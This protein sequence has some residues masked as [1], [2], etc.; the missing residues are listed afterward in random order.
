M[1][2]PSQKGILKKSQEIDLYTLSQN[3]ESLDLSKND[4]LNFWLYCKIA[5]CTGL[6]SIDILEMEV[7]Y[8]DFKTGNVRL[9]EKK[10]KKEV[11]FELHKT[12]LDKINMSN[13]FVIWNDKYKSKVSLMTINRRLKLIYPNTKGISSHSIRKATAKYVYRSFDNDIIKAM[14]FLN[15]SSPTMTKNYLGV[16]NDEKKAVRRVL[17]VFI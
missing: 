16:T 12:I 14:T 10:T 6:R 4:N 5:T 13:E 9:T 2:R 3:L 1:K 17:N 15:H 7:S 8:I 11:E